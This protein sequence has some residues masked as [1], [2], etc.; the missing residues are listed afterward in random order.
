MVVDG[1]DTNDGTEAGDWDGEYAIRVYAP[2]TENQIKVTFSDVTI[3]DADVGML[4]RG[5]DV[6]L[7]G[8]IT[9][10]NLDWGGIGVDSIGS[11]PELRYKS[12][13]TVASGCTINYTNGE[14]GDVVKP[15]I[16]TERTNE[17]ETVS[18]SSLDKISR[19][20]AGSE[21]QG[22]QTWYVT[23]NF[24][25]TAAGIHSEESVQ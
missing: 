11:N 17:Y 15:A 20:E 5:G 4:V 22:H 9:F 21:E 8:V 25:K 6:T 18:A 10:E 16:W 23:T 1:I 19:A 13:V 24:D 3:K 2:D 7:E 12:T 14:N